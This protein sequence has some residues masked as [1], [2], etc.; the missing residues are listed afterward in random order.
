MGLLLLSL[1]SAL[2][3]ALIVFFICE[4]KSLKN[5]NFS[6]MKGLFTEELKPSE[7]IG[8]FHTIKYMFVYGVLLVLFDLLI[9]K[10]VFIPN[11]FT[12]TDIMAYT[13]VPSLIGSW[14]ILLVKWTYQPVIKLVSSFMYGAGFITSAIFAFAITYF[15]QIS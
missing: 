4:E 12:T 10:N 1:G 5:A 3:F 6:D 14:I 13:F 15:P 8:Q 11:N 9:A 7:C 2:V